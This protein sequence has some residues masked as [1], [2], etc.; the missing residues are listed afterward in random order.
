VNRAAIV[1]W[2]VIAAVPRAAHAQPIDA[3]VPPPEPAKPE[4]EP[5]PEPVVDA[6][7]PANQEPSPAE[8]A[9][10]EAALGSDATD[11]AATAPATAA[12]VA[13]SF[14]PDI[15]L[16]LDIAAGWFSED[17][18]LQ[19]GG[20]D[21]TTTGFNLQSLELAIGK[22]VDPYFRF[23]ANLAFSQ[24]G[25]E[26]EEVYATTLALP[27]N[28]QVRAGQFLT[29][30][31]RLNPTHPHRWD[32]VDQPFAIGRVFGGEGNRGL[33][34]ELSY[35]TPAPFFLELVASA[36]EANGEGSARSF[37]GAADLPVESPLD[38]VSLL[39]AK[40]FFDLSDNWSLA[41]GQSIASG[42]N[43]TGR[44]TRTNV[45]GVDLY[46]K[47]RPITFG[48]DTIVALQSEWL[49]RRRQTPDGVAT[50]VTGYA[51]VLWKFAKRWGTAVRYEAGTANGDDLDPEWVDDRHRVS[52]NLTFWPTEF[53]RLRL[54]GSVDDPR[55][56]ANPIWAAFL[57]AEFSVGA[58]GAH[59]Y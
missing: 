56:Q 45:M 22:A 13:S 55:W 23:D 31:G 3:G 52:V 30:F 34:V 10:I 17:D 4:P 47:Y 44:D 43:G 19:T 40:E 7:P 28:L 29:R 11:A 12:P 24:E 9:E 2:I 14:N 35:L 8:L 39:A 46:L 33:G 42:P 53:S 59:K 27:A 58:H 50:D 21:P 1:L 49:Y 36:T 20:H 5:P 57:A 6:P 32:F 26:I 25:V 15:A 54:Q 48:S 16:I 37:F 41:L 38:F 51:Y 18:N